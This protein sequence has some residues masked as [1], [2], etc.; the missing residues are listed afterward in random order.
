MPIVQEKEEN[1]IQN[2]HNS[3]ESNKRAGSRIVVKEEKSLL[4]GEKMASKEEQ[5]VLSGDKMVSN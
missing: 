3:C 4:A 5:N 2:P 1:M